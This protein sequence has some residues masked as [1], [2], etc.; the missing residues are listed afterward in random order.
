MTAPRMPR[1]GAP[2]HYDAD[3]GQLN[4]D[5]AKTI[6]LP[7]VR[8]KRRSHWEERAKEQELE[9]T[10]ALSLLEQMTA[11]L[12]GIFDLQKAPPKS[13]VLAQLSQ[14]IPASGAY[15]L[16]FPGA[17][18]KAVLLGNYASS[19][20]MV[21][22]A[23]QQGFTPATGAGVFRVLSGF[24]RVMPAAGQA[25]T[26]YGTPGAAFDLT[27]FARP[28]PPSASAIGVA[29]TDPQL[30]LAQGAN[31]AAS[32]LGSVSIVPAAG[33]T[34]VLTD[35]AV[36]APIV[37]PPVTITGLAAGTLNL[38]GGPLQVAL[39]TPQPASAPNVPIV[40][41]VAAAAIT[42]AYSLFVGGFDS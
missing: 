18:Y 15:T 9:Q 40:I 32:A 23:P 10:V 24:Q 41:S 29:T 34:A 36:T 25:I 31:F 27:L 38:A 3:A 2:A 11:H 6:E 14:V 21:G 33:L 22:A 30:P 13:D 28:R 39:A 12:G 7:P 5:I 16:T 19:D 17:G 26:V 8:P 20:L 42:T 35:Y 1:K 4:T 37:V